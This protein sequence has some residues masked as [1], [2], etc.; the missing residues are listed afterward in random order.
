LLPDKVGGSPKQWA[1]LAGL[2]VLGIVSYFL[3]RNPSAPPVQTTSQRAA[4]QEPVLPKTP[5]VARRAPNR[6][7]ATNRGEEFRPTLKLPEGMDVSKIDPTIK[8]ALLEKLRHVPME[9]GSRGSV[10]A[11]GQP[12]PPPAPKVDPKAPKIVPKDLAANKPEPPKPP[13]DPPKPAAPPIPL[14]FYGYGNSR[15]GPKRAFFLDGEDIDVVT[16]N[17]IIKNRYKIIRIGVNSVVV[18]DLN[19]KSQQTLP[20]VEELAG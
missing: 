7:T 15:G 17:D 2:A 20:L 16:E 10:F 1:I 4:P 19:F 12:P 14:K 3:N 11:F 5:P 8:L 6:A 13:S 9:L 18:E